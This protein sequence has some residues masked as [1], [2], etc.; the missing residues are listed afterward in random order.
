[1]TRGTWVGVDMQVAILNTESE[2]SS[3][4]KKTREEEQPTLGSAL[5]PCTGQLR[6]D[7]ARRRRSKMA[8][9]TARA[10]WVKGNAAADEA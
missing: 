5:H 1:M 2:T 3:T 8:I 4:P 9:N 7:E 6:A 10:A